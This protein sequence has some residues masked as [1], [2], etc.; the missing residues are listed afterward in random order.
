MTPSVV[1]PA[2]WLHARASG[3]RSSHVRAA[4]CELRTF[5]LVSCARAARSR[6]A[7]AFRYVVHA[8]ATAA[9]AIL[10]YR[11]VVEEEYT[12]TYSSTIIIS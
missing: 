6:I 7:L 1:V 3:A 5:A 12:C 8:A 11:Y 4:V 9:A 10:Q 2:V